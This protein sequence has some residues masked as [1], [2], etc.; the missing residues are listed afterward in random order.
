M[1]DK[2]EHFTQK[3]VS[4][5]NIQRDW[6]QSPVK[7]APQSESSWNTLS[8]QTTEQNKNNESIRKAKRDCICY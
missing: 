3:T 5:I 2:T 8:N 4:N 6:L 1:R 7:D